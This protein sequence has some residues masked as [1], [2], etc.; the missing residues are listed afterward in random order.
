[1]KAAADEAESWKTTPRTI[2]LDW[3][4]SR[5]RGNSL[6]HGVHQDAQK[7]SSTTLPLSSAS[8]RGR[9]ARSNVL[10]SGAGW[11]T[12]GPALP[13]LPLLRHAVPHAGAD[14]TRA[15]T[16]AVASVRLAPTAG[17]RR[18]LTLSAGRHARSAD[19]PARRGAT[20]AP[21]AS[22]PAAAA[23]WRTTG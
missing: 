11:P 6:R 4:A 5:S 23:P 18:R 13:P 12:G 17:R 21:P 9:P 3:L 7:F 16:A 22:A 20:S 2:T 8:A 19:A 14:R 1:M 10:N 15:A